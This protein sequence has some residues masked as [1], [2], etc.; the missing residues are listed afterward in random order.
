M[1]AY[2]FAASRIERSFGLLNDA[3]LGAG[4]ADMLVRRQPYASTSVFGC[5]FSDHDQQLVAGLSYFSMFAISDFHGRLSCDSYVSLGMSP[6]RI[7]RHPSSGAAG[8]SSVMAK[9]IHVDESSLFRRSFH[10]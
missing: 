7:P 2:V 9:Y 1:L 4:I 6:T 10:I 3:R 5:G 8:V